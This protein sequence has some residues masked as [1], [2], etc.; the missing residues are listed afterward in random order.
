MS[1]SP[2]HNKTN[3]CISSVIL[4]VV[5]CANLH[6]LYNL[7]LKKNTHG[8]VLILVKLQAEVTVDG[9]DGK[10]FQRIMGLL[11]NVFCGSNTQYSKKI[12]QEIES[13]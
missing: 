10:K 12:W 7:R 3:P 8:G 5:R 9:H 4:Y 2:Y 13:R 11:K 1:I 6:H